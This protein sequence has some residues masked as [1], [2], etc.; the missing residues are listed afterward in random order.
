[1]YWDPTGH[2]PSNVPNVSQGEFY[3]WSPSE[4][5]CYLSDIQYYMEN[6][7]SDNKTTQ[8]AAIDAKVSA[9]EIRNSNLPSVVLT[10]G[11]GVS[12]E[13]AKKTV[14]QAHTTQLRVESA[15]ASQQQRVDAA[16]AWQKAT[17]N[18]NSKKSDVFSSF[19]SFF[20]G[21]LDFYSFKDQSDLGLATSGWG[22][23]L[24]TFSYQIESEMYDA[25]SSSNYNRNAYSAYDE[26]DINTPTTKTNGAKTY[27]K[28]NASDNAGTLKTQAVKTPK[29]LNTIPEDL[30]AFGNSTQPRNARAVQ[31][32]GVE[33][34]N[35]IIGNSQTE[36]KGASTF[37]NVN[38]APLTGKYYT[39]P[40]GTRLPD[41]LGVVA[42]GIEVNPSSGHTE[43]HYTICPT[44]PMTVDEF[45]KLYQSLP[46]KY[47]GKK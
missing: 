7:D 43:T 4:Q 24:F 31:D 2:V 15:I 36:V 34:G 8:A 46:W 40:A 3:S 18:I 30:N 9:I 41:G 22:V 38:K 12:K 27:P 44:K 23:N 1:M 35:D 25:M 26:D 5:E 14:N 47:G 45:N 29:I 42:D 21:M 20:K 11:D 37:A 19:S 16:I 28:G 13:L 10:V 39:L 17:N 33:S 32:F 6:K